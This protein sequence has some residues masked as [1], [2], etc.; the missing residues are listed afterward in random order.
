ML[1]VGCICKISYAFLLFVLYYYNS[2]SLNASTISNNWI[3]FSSSPREDEMS[4][5]IQSFVRWSVLVFVVITVILVDHYFFRLLNIV[6]THGKIVR[7]QRGSAEL[8]IV[9]HWILPNFLFSVNKIL[10]FCPIIRQWMAAEP[11]LICCVKCWT[12]TI[13]DSLTN[14]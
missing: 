3:T 11:L 4:K 2:H 1:E 13:H 8:N 9:W 12:R 7:H 10:I 6:V 5:T 14:I